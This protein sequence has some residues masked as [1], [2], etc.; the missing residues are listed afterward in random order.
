VSVTSPGV[1]A[2][3]TL[4]MSALL[5]STTSITGAL[6]ATDTAGNIY[7]VA[8]DGN[9]GSGGDRSVILVA[10]NIKA[11]AA[12]DTITLTYPSATE[13]HLTV[14]E[15]SG[16]TG[17]DKTAG[18]FGVGSSFN[19]GAVTITQANEILIGTAGV[20]SATAPTWAA[21][22]TA[23]PTL[24]VTTDYL[25]TAYRIVTATGSY[26]ATG[27]TTNQWMANI[28]TLTTG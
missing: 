2:G 8:R 25:D 15:F 3:H 4:V 6:S 14:D 20:E 16:V 9:D 19:S 24:A 7:T 26:T 13:T 5:S 17:V 18:A 1:A 23:L 21:G 22:W 12:G 11:L 28:V 10:V 27:T